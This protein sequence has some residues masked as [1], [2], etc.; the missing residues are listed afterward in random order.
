MNDLVDG[1]DECV[2]HEGHGVG[3]SGKGLPFQRCV[4]ERK[5]ITEGSL[6]NVHIWSTVKESIDPSHVTN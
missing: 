2:V 3:L 5:S 1:G 4:R 6:V